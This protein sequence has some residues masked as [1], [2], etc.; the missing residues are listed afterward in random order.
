[1][2]NNSAHRRPGF[3]QVTLSY[4]ASDVRATRR[5]QDRRRRNQGLRSRSRQ[6]GGRVKLPSRVADSADANDDRV[7]NVFKRSLFAG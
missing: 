5:P 6:H 1:M 4:S 3:V 7:A 2:L